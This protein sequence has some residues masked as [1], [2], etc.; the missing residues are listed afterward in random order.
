[1]SSENK[2]DEPNFDDLVDEEYGNEFEE[3]RGRGIEKDDSSQ[4]QDYTRKN[5]N[6]TDEKL[7]QLP[8][9]EITVYKYS[10]RGKGDLHESVIV[11][12][13]PFFL[14]YDY[15]R[16]KI[17]LIDK[18]EE[19]TRILLPPSEEEYP[20]D[21]YEFKNINEINTVYLERVKKETNESLYKK[22]KTNVKKYNDRDKHSISLVSLDI[23][24]SFFQDKFSTIHYDFVI[25][26]NG[27]GKTAVG[28]TFESLGYR[29]VMMTDPTPA[30]WFRVL[31]KIEWGQCTIIADEADRIDQSYETMN[32]LK[33]GYQRKAKIP[34]MNFTNT[35]Q[36]FFWTFGFKLIL[37]E[38][39]PSLFTAKGVLDRSFIMNSY[40]GFPEYDI[41]EIRNP[42]GNPER[43]KL[44]DELNDLR[45][46][47]F[48]FR[49]VHF[50][51]SLPEMK[52]PFDGRDKELTKPHLQ[53]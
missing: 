51:D 50:K 41:K 15:Q 13:K 27:T 7:P 5:K 18:I 36:D 31:G 28:D 23:F 42:Q 14:R 44:F 1:M 39:S 17:V 11:S 52:M 9:K 10:H 38:S 47:L 32:I 19:P 29:V 37:S 46:L 25:G 43:Q 30:N 16:D 6:K 20:Y 40:K 24:S 26:D 53:L 45:K 49:L 22:I 48:I 4:Q 33:T 3:I 8:K 34:R 35:K 12:G 2:E 21:P